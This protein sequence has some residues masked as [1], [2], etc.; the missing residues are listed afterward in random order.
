MS[1]I[2]K[3]MKRYSIN[4]KP[5]NKWSTT[6]ITRLCSNYI[7]DPIFHSTHATISLCHKYICHSIY[8]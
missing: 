6:A 8:S 2:L 1:V 5:G 4:P 7:C 3:I